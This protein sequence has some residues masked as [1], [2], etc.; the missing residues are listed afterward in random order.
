LIADRLG[1][2][3]VIA[4]TVTTAIGKAGPGRLKLERKRGIGVGANHEMSE[5]IVNA[6]NQAGLNARLYSKYEMVKV[7]DQLIS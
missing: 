1:Q 5:A 2:D 4:G 7:I 3:K 6:M